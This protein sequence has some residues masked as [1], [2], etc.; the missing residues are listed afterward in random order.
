MED[1]I[2]TEVH[3]SAMMRYHTLAESLRQTRFS[4]DN[5]SEYLNSARLVSQRIEDLSSQAYLAQRFLWRNTTL[6]RYQ[7]IGYEGREFLEVS[8]LAGLPDIRIPYWRSERTCRETGFVNKVDFDASQAALRGAQTIRVDLDHPSRVIPLL[9]VLKLP[10]YVQLVKTDLV[11]GQPQTVLGFVWHF[12]E[13]FEVL[14]SDC[15]FYVYMIYE[16]TSWMQRDMD[17]DVHTYRPIAYQIWSLDRLNLKRSLFKI[18]DN[19]AT[20]GCFLNPPAVGA[21]GWADLDEILSDWP[22][23]AGLVDNLFQKDIVLSCLRLYAEA[24]ITNLEEGDVCHGYQTEDKGIGL[25]FEL[26]T[27]KWWCDFSLF[28]FCSR[29]G[30]I[31]WG[32][33]LIHRASSQLTH[34]FGSKLRSQFDHVASSCPEA[35]SRLCEFNPGLMDAIMPN[36]CSSWFLASTFLY[37]LC[38]GSLGNPQRHF[39]A[40]WRADTFD[41]GPVIQ[42]DDW[43]RIHPSLNIS[44][45]LEEAELEFNR[46]LSSCSGEQNPFALDRDNSVPQVTVRNIDPPDDSISLVWMPIGTRMVRYNLEETL[47]AA[48][49]FM[50]RVHLDEDD[51]PSV[52]FHF[53]RGIKF[54]ASGLLESLDIKELSTALT[55]CDTQFWPFLSFCERLAWYLGLEDPPAE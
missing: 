20:M 40:P 7:N 26:L 27:I 9:E 22:Q 1:T 50:L 15:V 45:R 8:A 43:K 42:F 36:W 52:L 16:L 2:E 55:M 41:F 14:I 29:F 34:R 25:E 33:S 49:V 31:G 4:A 13:G 11:N 3:Q 38:V 47:R 23:F 39:T 6:N 54:S 51:E 30:D 37:R 12:F 44:I 21:P 32:N 17:T 10:C 48:L 5:S 18:G 19:D 35:H 53:E 28:F 24:G 46:I